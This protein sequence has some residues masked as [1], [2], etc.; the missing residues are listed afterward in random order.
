M[1]GSVLPARSD[2]DALGASGL[3]SVSSRIPV[4]LKPNRRQ[5]ER[6]E[7]SSSTGADVVIPVAD[8][9]VSIEWYSAIHGRPPDAR[10]SRRAVSWLQHDGYTFTLVRSVPHAGTA[11]VTITGDD[12]E[13][14]VR[15]VGGRDVVIPE[16]RRSSIFRYTIVADPDDNTVIFVQFSDY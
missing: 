13:L 7:L 14:L 4:S 8:L 1:F 5:P 3:A 9:R 15:R 16:Q 10:L 11:S 12:F 2:G 6:V